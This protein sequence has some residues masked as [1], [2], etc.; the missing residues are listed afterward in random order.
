MEVSYL[1]INGY[2]RARHRMFGGDGEWHEVYCLDGSLPIKDG[3]HAIMRAIT[4]AAAE[5]GRRMK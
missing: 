3:Q 4:L 1:P 2:A 5:V